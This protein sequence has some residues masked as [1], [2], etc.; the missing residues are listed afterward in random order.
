MN[1]LCLKK[2]EVTIS[3]LRLN[4]SQFHSKPGYYMYAYKVT[5]NATSK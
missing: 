5:T 2:K 1:E 3:E 4:M